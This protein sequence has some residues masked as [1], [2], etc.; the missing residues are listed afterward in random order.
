MN[1]KKEKNKDSK[2]Y[3]ITFK[4]RERKG[5]QGRFQETKISKRFSIPDPS[6]S[7]LKRDLRQWQNRVRGKNT[8]VN[9]LIE[10]FYSNL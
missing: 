2:K 1:R 10:N 3:M 7:R 9:S 8:T 6:T 5:Y 4:K